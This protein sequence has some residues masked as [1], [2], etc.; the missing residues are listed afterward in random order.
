MDESTLGAPRR[1]SQLK[2]QRMATAEQFVADA[3]SAARLIAHR[4]RDTLELDASF[5]ADGA[6]IERQA[7]VDGLDRHDIA[8]AQS[9]VLDATRR[10]RML[11]AS[12]VAFDDAGAAADAECAALAFGAP[13]PP[14]P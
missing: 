12:A 8:E 9:L 5:G 1:P 13:P 2:R 11:D 7:H 6:A 4:C 3:L 14:P 10:Y